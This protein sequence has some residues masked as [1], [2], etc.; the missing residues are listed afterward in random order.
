MTHVIACPAAEEHVDLAALSAGL[1]QS[2]SGQTAFKRLSGGVL[3]AV[4]QQSDS[5]CDDDGGNFPRVSAHR[6]TLVP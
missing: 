4:R 2:G 5:D 6:M 1:Q 3:A